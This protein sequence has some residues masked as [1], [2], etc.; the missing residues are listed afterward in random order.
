ALGCAQLERLP[1]ILDAKRELFQRYKTAFMGMEGVSLMAE[2]A[3]SKSNYWLQTL[4]LNEDQA[5]Q[6]DEV[7]KTSNEAGLMTRPV[8]VLMNKLEPFKNCPQMDLTIAQSLSERLINIPSS[9]N[10]VALS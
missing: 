3:V 2:P 1:I 4:L 7:L 9:S 8:W 10:L 5:T 6:R